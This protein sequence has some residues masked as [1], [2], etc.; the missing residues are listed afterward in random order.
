M[1]STSR[2]PCA[3]PSRSS[4]SVP[5]FTSLSRSTSSGATPTRSATSA[6]SGT[7]AS[8]CRLGA[9]STEPASRS[10]TPGAPM[11]MRSTATSSAATASAIAAATA[12]PPVAGV[13]S[14]FCATTVSPSSATTWILVPPRST[15]TSG[16]GGRSLGAVRGVGRGLLVGHAEVP[17]EEEPLPLRVTRDALTVPAEL[18]VVRRQQH[19][20]G[21]HAIAERVDQ[22]AVAGDPD[23]LPVGRG[24]AE[25]DD[26]HRALRRQ[27]L[28][29]GGLLRHEGSRL[30]GGAPRPEGRGDRHGLPV[31]LEGDPHPVAGVQ[32]R[33]AVGDVARRLHLLAVDGGDHVAG[34]DPGRL[35]AAAVDDLTHEGAGVAVEAEAV[36]DG[37]LHV[38]EVDGADT[39]EGGAAHVA[40]TGLEPLDERLELVDRERDAEFLRGTV[41]LRRRHRRVDADDLALGV[42]ERATGVALVDGRVG[43]DQVREVLVVRRVEIAAERGHDP[44]RDA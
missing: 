9:R 8:I 18:R 14:F 31:A 25:V 13:G 11:P 12:S 19:E 22:T 38:V 3:A 44:G 1:H 5:T 34:L 29:V 27:L 7:D 24:R 28:L 6:V 20:P 35:R 16:T 36:A 10:M 23:D 21:V 33:D 2:P 26:L 15:P 32:L 4:A 43:L 42:D 17:L 41:R 37:R 39:E 40:T 30:P